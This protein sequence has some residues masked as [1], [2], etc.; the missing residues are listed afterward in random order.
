MCFDYLPD[1]EVVLRNEAAVGQ[2]AFKIRIALLDQRGAYLCGRSGREPERFELIHLRAGAIANPDH[3]IHQSGGWHID[4]ALLT[5]AD[6]LEAV[7]GVRNA[8]RYE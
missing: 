8:A 6:H 3:L 4:H 5:A 1:E 2:A 7:I